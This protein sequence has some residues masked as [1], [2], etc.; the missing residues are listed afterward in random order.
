MRLY[1]YMSPTEFYLIS[2]I[3]KD[4]DPVPVK[5]QTWGG[6]DYWAYWTS[7]MLAPPLAATV[8]TYATPQSVV[9]VAYSDCLVLCRWALRLGRRFRSCFSAS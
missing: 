6:I 5:A 1:P 2:G 4:L 7:D 3:K 9:V 8:S